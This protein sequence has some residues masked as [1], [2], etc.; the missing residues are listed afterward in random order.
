MATHGTLIF[1]ALVGTPHCQKDRFD[2][3]VG[4]V[5]VAIAFLEFLKIFKYL[6]PGFGRR[7][8]LAPVESDLFKLLDVFGC[9]LVS[10]L[11]K[12]QVGVCPTL[13]I[14]KLS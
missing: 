5:A 1:I 7:K 2:L 13:I 6:L 14:D 10:F 8:L 3:I 11:S 9:T 4:N 12:L